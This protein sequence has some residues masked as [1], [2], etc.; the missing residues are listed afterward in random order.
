MPVSTVAPAVWQQPGTV[1][2]PP[3][4]WSLLDWR[5]E[6]DREENGFTFR[7]LAAERQD[8]KFYDDAPQMID[9]YHYWRVKPTSQIEP[10]RFIHHIGVKWIS[11]D[12]TLFSGCPDATGALEVEMHTTLKAPPPFNTWQSFHVGAVKITD[13]AR[14]TDGLPRI[15]TKPILKTLLQADC[16]RRVL[17]QSWDPAKAV[18][19][20]NHT[21]NRPWK[22]A[23]ANC[24]LCVSYDA[25]PNYGM[26]WVEEQVSL[27]LNPDGWI[28]N[29]DD[30]DY[31][32][33][34]TSDAADFGD[35]DF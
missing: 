28:Y 7:Y 23:P 20:V 29:L 2:E 14:C 10:L 3:T 8:G 30:P 35:G 15:P 18:Q 9:D 19:L 25:V 34:S 11:N 16:S 1:W 4:Y 21:M 24:W 27:M 26:A 31:E 13:V 17:L 5:Q 33:M 22:G 12:I 6:A 32:Y